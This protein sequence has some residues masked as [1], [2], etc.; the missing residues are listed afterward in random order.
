MVGGPQGEAGPFE[1]RVRPVD[2]VQ[3]AD[4]ADGLL[5]RAH[6]LH[7]DFRPGGDLGGAGRVVEAECGGHGGGATGQERASM[8]VVVLL[9]DRV[10]LPGGRAA[11]QLALP[12]LPAGGE[13]QLLQGRAGEHVL[14]YALVGVVGTFDLA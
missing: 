5:H 11:A 12:C 14:K 6:I 10:A 8:H 1:Q 4:V 2:V 7:A 13:A 9:V 3:Q